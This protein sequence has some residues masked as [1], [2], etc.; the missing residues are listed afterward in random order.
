MT[1]AQRDTFFAAPTSRRAFSSLLVLGL[2]LG[3][4]QVSA[5]ASSTVKTP[6]ACKKVF[7]QI[8]KDDNAY[9]A[10]QYAVVQAAKNYEASNSLT[11][12]LNYNQSYVSAISAA[13]VELKFFI[14][15]PKCYPTSS[16]AQAQ[17]SVTANLTAIANI[18]KE[19]VN[20]QVVGDPKKM[21]TFKPVCLLK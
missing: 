19:N 18:Y 2:I 6:A 12:R 9:I 3:T 16:M 21:T 20:S 8:V 17:K 15:N 7:T 11:N 4:S 13:N 10:Q 1:K 5:F 14:K